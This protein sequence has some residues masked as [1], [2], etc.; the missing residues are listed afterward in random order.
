MAT[1]T[2]LSQMTKNDKNIHAANT[3]TITHLPSILSIYQF[4][5]HKVAFLL[6]HVKL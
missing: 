2:L 6:R 3:H 4:I 1:Y 5:T